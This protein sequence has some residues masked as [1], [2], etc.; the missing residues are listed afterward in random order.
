MELEEF[1]ARLR[2]SRNVVFF[3][4]AAIAPIPACPIF[5][6]RAECGQ[7]INRFIF[8]ISSPAKPRAFNIG[9]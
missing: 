8:K 9:G 5:A 7:N 4:G 2:Q 3:T 6:A 1:A